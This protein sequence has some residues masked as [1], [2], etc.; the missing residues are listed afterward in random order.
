VRLF[1]C[2]AFR[3]CVFLGVLLLGCASFHR[4]TSGKTDCDLFVCRMV[5]E[6]DSVGVQT[7]M[8]VNKAIYSNI[9]VS[10]HAHDQS[11]FIHIDS[12]KDTL[13]QV[14]TLCTLLVT[15]SLLLF[16]GNWI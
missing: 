14:L 11:A 5:T 16:N 1:G 12:T 13:S 9:C 4:C 7:A 8:F 10:P 2:A 15:D 6:A 3:V